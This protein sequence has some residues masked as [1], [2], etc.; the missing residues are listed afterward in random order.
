MSETTTE[1]AARIIAS[2]FVHGTSGD[3]ALSAAQT[4]DSLGLLSPAADPFAAPGRNRP[5]PSPA[6]VRMLAECRRAQDAAR[7]ASVET[8]GLPGTPSVTA[9]RGEVQFVV[10]PR[11]LAD[12]K[13][14]MHEL[15]VGDARGDS[16]GAA[17][18]VRFTYG[19]VRARLVGV[20]V[21]AMYGEMHAH[22]G[23]RTAVRP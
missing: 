22:T 2:E 15:G 23:R 11:S 5:A 10:H 1:R 20:G 8:A 12:W 7:T 18:V 19:G 3:P 13:Q 9:A 14:W 21:P 16:T 6:A 17:M 4:L